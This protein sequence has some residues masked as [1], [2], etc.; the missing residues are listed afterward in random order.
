MEKMVKK[1]RS[2]RIYPMTFFDAIAALLTVPRRPEKA[3]R[4]KPQQPAG[5]AHV[6]A[7]N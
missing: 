6:P 3:E 7:T 4:D 1:P 5:P 2:E